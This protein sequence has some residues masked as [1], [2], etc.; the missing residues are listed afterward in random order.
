MSRTLAGDPCTVDGAPL[1]AGNRAPPVRSGSASASQPQRSDWSPFADRD[2]F[3]LADFLF[4]DEQM[5]AGNIDALLSIWSSAAAKYRGSPPFRNHDELYETID[6]I[7]HGG[8]PWRH[9]SVGYNG[10][11][12]PESTDVPPWMKEQFSIY[13]RDPREIAIG[14]LANPDFKD[15]I[16]FGPL[17]E[18]DSNGQ[19]RLR[20][21]MGGNWSWRQAVRIHSC[22][23]SFLHP[24]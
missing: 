24:L 17:R 10:S 19:R 23:S 18:R 16:D 9:F 22:P 20:D 5:S 14:M 7:S 2:A 6:C 3:E 11:V 13:Y 12:D 8:T 1:P 4:S 21:F 15:E